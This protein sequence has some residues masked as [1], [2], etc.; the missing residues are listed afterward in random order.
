MVS[1]PTAHDLICRPY[2]CSWQ[3]DRV[4]KRNLQRL[5]RIDSYMFWSRTWDYSKDDKRIKCYA[6]ESWWSPPSDNVT[7][8]RRADRWPLPGTELRTD[9]KKR[10]VDPVNTNSFERAQDGLRSALP[11]SHRQDRRSLDQ[12]YADHEISARMCVLHFSSP[13]ESDA[14]IFRIPSQLFSA[15]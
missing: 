9:L 4:V 6:T 13:G 14:C 5:G 8:L 3:S 7:I 12:R 11:E 2:H 10:D 1:P 15:V